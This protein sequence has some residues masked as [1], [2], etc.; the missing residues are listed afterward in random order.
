MWHHESHA[1]LHITTVGRHKPFDEEPLGVSV[2]VN[3]SKSSAE[4]PILQISYNLDEEPR[5]IFR[6]IGV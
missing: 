3:P 1:K 4:L 6:F 2:P 5:G